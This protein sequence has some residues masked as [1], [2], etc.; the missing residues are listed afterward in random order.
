MNENARVFISCGQRKT[1][2]YLE[3][4]THDNV[5]LTPPELAVA[6]KIFDKL[7]K[8]GYE[9]YLALEQ[10]T[11]QGVKEGI[12]EK[13]KNTEYFLFIDFKREGLYKDGTIDFNSGEARGS[14]FTNQEL[15]I[16]TFQDL[17]ILA[18]QEEG[19]KKEDGILKFIQ[20]NCKTFSDRKKLPTLVISQVRKK[21]N[22]NWRNELFIEPTVS[23]VDNVFNPNEGIGKY[24]HIKVTNKHKDRVARNCVAYVERVE[25]LAT[26]DHR[27]LELVELKWKGVITT[28]VS[29]PPK[30]QRHVDAFHVN[31]NQPSTAML[32]LNTHITDF[33]GYGTEYQVSGTGDHQIDYVV[34]SDNFAPAR[35]RFKLHIGT[36]VTDVTFQKL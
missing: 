35:A 33:S 15:A 23:F 32:G 6:K 17:E 18:F 24:F 14:L 12:F 13:L 10:Q 8:M 30:S 34:F 9:P 11:L 19:V 20:A 36:N 7:K 31:Y 4:I 27:V 1:S 5:S 21:W 29:I 3:I 22:P 25:N 26:G 28:G 16:A 2:D